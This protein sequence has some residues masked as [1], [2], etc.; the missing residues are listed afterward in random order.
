MGY[1]EDLLASAGQTQN[2]MD[3]FIDA[4]QRRLRNS[5]RTLEQNII[6]QMADWKT[7]DGRLVSPKVNLAQARALEA[8]LAN[9]FDETYGRE[10]RRMVKGFKGVAAQV[11]R[12]FK[13]LGMAASFTSV[14]NDVMKV[15]SDSTWNTF[16]QFGT[17]AQNQ[18]I[19]TMYNGVL[20]KA[21]MSVMIN[22]IS[23][24]LSGFRDKR[25]RSMSQYAELYAND[26]TMIFH[27]EVRL[28]KASDL[29]I[30]NFVY[31]GSAKNT[32]RDF[33]RE[34]IGKTFSRDEIDSWNGLTWSG[35]SGPPITNRGGYN[36]RHSWV[37]VKKT[38]ADP[39]KI[40]E[41][42]TPPEEKKKR[43]KKKAK[44][45]PK[46]GTTAQL[47]KDWKEKERAFMKATGKGG[48]FEGSRSMKY[49]GNGYYDPIK[50]GD[51]AEVLNMWQ[52]QSDAR[53]A[54]YRSL[55]RE[56]KDV[57]RH[58][59]ITSKMLR[60]KVIEKELQKAVASGGPGSNW[61]YDMIEKY[62]VDGLQH[63][64]YRM[65]YEMEQAGCRINW[66]AMKKIKK[67]GISRWKGRAFYDT[68]KGEC[69]MYI[70]DDVADTVAH[71]YGHAIDAWFGSGNMQISG[72]YGNGT[73]LVWKDSGR[74]GM[75]F[76]ERTKLREFY[77]RQMNGE[78]GTF[79][80][81]DGLY[82]KGS[83]ITNY[84]GRRYERFTRNVSAPW[85]PEVRLEGIGNEFW[86]M[87]VQRYND[88]Y[89]RAYGTYNRRT[90]QLNKVLTKY[91][92]ALEE[93]QRASIPNK[94]TIKL[95]E[96]KI[97]NQKR[98]ISEYTFER[99]F[100][101][102]KSTGQWSNVRQMY[103]EFADWLENVFENVWIT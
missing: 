23:S 33:C 56:A 48:P 9:M 8:K 2:Y 55:S 52:E 85:D 44:P 95:W 39:V 82:D 12:Q 97:A 18:L 40:E 58:K 29:G 63:V 35:K 28:K 1:T 64:S 96:D 59:L 30:N 89:R 84:E 31:Y 13:D 42:V 68:T 71:E 76:E 46:T 83:W 102:V 26:A 94:E 32:T 98:V 70:G 4:H 43:K 54:W 93:A 80:N 6:D 41:E 65:L 51:H 87:N 81:G 34:R 50:Y 60:K 99:I 86:A 5:I 103:P 20:G 49:F 74:W 36:C 57:E 15:L 25:G 61:T 45:K 77:V 3:S 24:I 90:R 75:G 16:N 22:E 14:D 100:D 66:K 38:K 62:T 72:Y 91:E 79:T 37:P 10:A 53:M 69:V 47:K 11:Q 17:A 67:G 7:T 27:N 92:D 73:G 78:T 21:G 19:D 101:D 88:A